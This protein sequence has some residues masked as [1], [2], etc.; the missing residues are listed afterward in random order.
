MHIPAWRA[1]YFGSCI[2]IAAHSAK[3]MKI[4]NHAGLFSWQQG[5]CAILAKALQD[6]Y[7]AGYIAGLANA[8]GDIDHV[9]WCV[10]SEDYY[11]YEPRLT[12]Y[13]FDSDGCYTE[14]ELVEKHLALE[15]VEVSVVDDVDDDAIAGREIP[16]PGPDEFTYRDALN[17]LIELLHEM[18]PNEPLGGL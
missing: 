13:Y 17:D 4:A 14:E 11:D 2:A 1:R 7:G 6:V 5:G 9:V 18:L 3:A 16:L 10:V 8:A 15:G 12:P